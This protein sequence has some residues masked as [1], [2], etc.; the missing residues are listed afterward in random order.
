MVTTK[1]EKILDVKLLKSDKEKWGQMPIG[2][3]IQSFNLSDDKNTSKVK[4]FIKDEIKFLNTEIKHL[5]K[6]S[7][8][9]YHPN[10]YI[11]NELEKRTFEIIL[12]RLT[13]K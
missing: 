9:V 13:N 11:S 7:P 4:T 2:R 3:I 8:V 12:G 5:K 6:Y 10:T 1:W